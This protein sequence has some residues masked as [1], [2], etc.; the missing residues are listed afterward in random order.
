MKPGLGKP[1]MTF[2]GCRSDTHNVCCL[3]NGKATEVAQLNHA[4]LLRIERCQGFESVVERDQLG[5]PFDR[6][7]D[8]FIQR[9][10]LEILATLF[11]IVLAR[12]VN[13]QATHYL[14][15]NSEKMSAI[16]PIHPRLIDEAKVGLMN[17]RGR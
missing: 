2:D 15:S 1:P 7:I 6:S 9:E 12:M 13:Q 5:A 8:V 14:C 3:F 16:L 11:R 17:Q 10:F 4:R